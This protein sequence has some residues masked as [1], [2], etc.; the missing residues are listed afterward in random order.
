MA[1]AGVD[2]DRLTAWLVR[3]P[4]RRTFVT[5]ATHIAERRVILVRLEAEGREGWGEAAPVPGHGG[6]DVDRLW[7][8]LLARGD[9]FG[10]SFVDDTPGMLGAA[11]EQA[12]TDLQ[13]RVLE[14]PLWRI[15]G[16]T[17]RVA[18][19]AAVGVADDGNPDPNQI[20]SAAAEGYRHIKVKVTPNTDAGRV[21]G[22]ISEYPRI[23][24]GADGNGT[25]APDHRAVLQALDDLA[26]AYIEQPGA[27]DDIDLHAELR[28]RMATPISLDESATSTH[29]IG[30]IVARAAADI[31]NLKVG[32][33]GTTTTRRLAGDLVAEGLRTRLGGLVET[34]IGRAHS[35][36]LG[37]HEFFSVVGDLAGSGRYFADDL[38]RPSWTV[39]DGW[40][41]LPDGPGIGV[42]VDVAAVTAHSEANVSIG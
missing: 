32:R 15:L 14:Q 16:S 35:A 39:S 18:A 22:L 29:R 2:V 25:L 17:R 5:A 13:A 33:F 21:A 37:G 20:E 30:Q 3:V 1:S 28:R 12:K 23:D 10:L 19:S 38:V 42:E 31:V 34:G 36:A 24:F 41:D 40:I 27:A 8:Q 4:L 11:L 6:N 26:L 7:A 9:A